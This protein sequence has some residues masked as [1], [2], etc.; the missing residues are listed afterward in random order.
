MIGLKK[1]L[2]LFLCLSF[3]FMQLPGSALAGYYA[4]AKTD[5]GITAKPPE[6]LT[7]PEEDIP[8]VEDDKAE[9]KG[10]NTWL[11]VIGGVLLLGALVGLAAGG[12]SDGGSDDP[13]EPQP[14]PT[15]TVP[16]S[17]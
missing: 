5:A 3:L 15:G 8:L 7:T 17:W 11:Y 16:V 13:D 4:K 1:L 14:A 12:G 10:S 2:I 9:K 6:A